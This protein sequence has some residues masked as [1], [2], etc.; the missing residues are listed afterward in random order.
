[1]A[2]M[3][4]FGGGVGGGHAKDVLRESSSFKRNRYIVEKPSKFTLKT[5]HIGT[6]LI[7]ARFF[8]LP[9]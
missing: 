1:M 9:K 2:P 5:S 8:E 7:A 3:M 6:I 4:S